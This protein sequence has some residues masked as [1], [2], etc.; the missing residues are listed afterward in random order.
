[1]KCRY[2][3]PWARDA[4]K[5]ISNL[6]VCIYY[7]Y[8]MFYTLWWYTSNKILKG[9]GYVWDSAENA[10]FPEIF[11]IAS[12]SWISNGTP[13]PLS[14]I[15]PW[16]STRQRLVWVWSSIRH[17]VTEGFVRNS[18]KRKKMPFWLI[19]KPNPFVWRSA[20][21][22]KNKN[23]YFFFEITV[24]IYPAQ[25]G[26]TFYK[27]NKGINSTKIVTWLESS[28]NAIIGGHTLESL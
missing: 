14:F 20:S 8:C 13:S 11:D 5:P 4:K 25:D 21:T 22:C 28:Q 24:F 19:F 7:S 10:L 6:K 15:L 12:F 16:T 2:Q 26:R 3:T 1:M 27:L 17:W 23:L 18:A 9:K